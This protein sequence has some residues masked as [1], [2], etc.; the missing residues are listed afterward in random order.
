MG[1]LFRHSGGGHEKIKG[2]S[3]KVEGGHHLKKSPQTPRL[4]HTYHLYQL[5]S[6]FV[7]QSHR[8]V[9]Y[10]HCVKDGTAYESFPFGLRYYELCELC[11]IIAAVVNLS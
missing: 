5:Y 1:S 11:I 6:L 10:A 2:P 3:H 9:C 8:P 4:V 7:V